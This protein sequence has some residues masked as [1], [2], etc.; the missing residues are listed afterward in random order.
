MKLQ[1]QVAQLVLLVLIA[2]VTSLPAMSQ[3]GYVLWGDVKIDDSKTAT[4]GPS[5][6]TIVLYDR[7]TKMVG[8]QTLGNRGRY[9]FANLRGEEYDLVIE[10]D[11]NEITRVRLNLAGS[12]STDVR[13]DFEF[14]WKD[15]SGGKPNT[16]GVVSAAD[17]YERSAANKALFEKAHTAVE[18]KDYANGVKLL[19]QIVENDAADFQAWTLLGTLYLAQEKREEAE[20]AYS[21]AIE[22]KP[23]Y[24]LPLIN[25]GKLLLMQKRF[26][27]AVDKLTR[28]VELQP[29]S[30]DANLFLGEAYLRLKKGSNAIPYLN[31]AGK[32]GNIQAHLDLGWLYNAA[33]LKDKAVVEYEEL[34]RKKPDYPDRKKLEQYI[35]E[36]K[37]P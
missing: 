10:A 6:V 4:P 9:R 15:R 16:T 17:L 25:L 18:K 21:K 26:D 23:T 33:G 5:S 19:N 1:R 28:A 34:L 7:S 24:A 35:S 32:L 8:R 2:F 31:E 30:P 22:T 27:D 36:N 13:Q 3:S 11:G 14:E 12:T 29:Q 20:K 37:K